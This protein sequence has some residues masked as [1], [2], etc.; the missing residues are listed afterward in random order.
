MSLEDCV[1]E[2]T[3]DTPRFNNQTGSA[4]ISVLMLGIIA[5]IILSIV[6]NATKHSIQKAGVRRSNTVLLNIAE[7]GNQDALSKLRANQIT[8]T[9]NNVVTIISNPDFGGGAYSVICSTG[10]SIDTIQLTSTASYMGKTKTIRILCAVTD[11]QIK[12]DAFNYAICAGGDI[13]WKGNGVLSV[14]S[15]AIFCNGSFSS[16]GTSDII[17]NLHAVKGVSLKG[18]TSITGEVWGLYISGNVKGPTH[19][20]SFKTVAIPELQT[21]PFYAR[22]VANNQVY[23]SDYHMKKNDDFTV[24]GE[25]MYINGDFKRTANGVFRGCIVATGDIELG[26]SGDYFKVDQ[27]PVAFSIN[28]KIDFSGNGEIHGLIFA[29]NGDFEK[30]GNGNITGT[31]ICKGDVKKA[32]GWDFLNYE[33]SNPSY[34]GCS[35]TSYTIISWHEL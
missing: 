21:A 19:E 26:G 13:T 10:A 20:G 1:K 7:A 31:I 14:A 16:V 22:A 29:Q 33:K 9:T 34:P 5:M 17:G 27:F 35:G 25:V 30:T 11:C 8:L 12:G 28:G 3:G 15:S 2:E 32:G 18:S 23:T 4:L 6:M 24:P